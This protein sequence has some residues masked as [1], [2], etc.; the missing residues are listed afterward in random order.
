MRPWGGGDGEGKTYPL[1]DSAMLEA[2]ALIAVV[3]EL[4]YARSL[5][6]VMEAVTHAART[7]LGADGVSFVLREG[8]LCY[9]ADENAIGPLWKGRRFPMSACISGW[10]MEHGQAVAIPDI[11][12]DPRIP[13]DAYRPTFVKSLAMAPVRQ[14]KPIA[15]IGAYWATLHN[16]GPKEVQR[17]QAVADAAALAIAYVQVNQQ[18]SD[19]ERAGGALHDR[20]GMFEAVMEHIPVGVMIAS[21]PGMTIQRVSA[22][23]L[24]R[25]RRKEEETA[26]I[27]A[28]EHPEAWQL[29]DQEGARLLP[30]DQLPLTRATKLGELVENEQLNLKLAD[31]SFL[32]ILCSAAPIR[33]H[34][35]RITGGVAVW[36][37][38]TERVKAD[39]AQQLLVRELNHRV[40]NLFSVVVG[41]IGLTAR[42][43]T[44]VKDMA[45]AL[46]GRVVALSRA[47]GM[48]GPA[49]AS[50]AVAR[51]SNLQDFLT[52]LISPHLTRADGHLRL[53]GPACTI[54]S[55]A[56]TSL[57]LVFHELATNAHKY[58]ALSSAE[59]HVDISW[60]E[61]G[62][63]LLLRWIE[64]GG[65]AIEA[66]PERLS[67]GSQ[68]IQ[69]TVKRQL[70]G[71]ISFD[72]RR[73]GLKVELS[74][75]A[76]KLY[77]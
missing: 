54:G 23:G 38:I 61:E 75:P 53:S 73:S 13:Q 69:R 37:D 74:L 70:G 10:C 6:E 14:E 36:Q 32:P 19:Q 63:H 76:A 33:D 44:N 51:E 72:W 4:S 26:A 15:A 67:F 58:G 40:K 48:I 57:A 17:L 68:L 27:N 7:L 35:G 50:D 77:S 18:A 11:S 46:I 56:I 29:F 59:G 39:E 64:R 2:E 21:A 47:H 16:P 49:I 45:D 42:S 5:A 71:N 28:E 20:S 66:A 12:L 8:D 9:Y 60:R 62:E 52:T 24:S 34:E 41:I 1:V 31:G 25:M 43:S 65:P 55:N 3:R 30:A 22:H